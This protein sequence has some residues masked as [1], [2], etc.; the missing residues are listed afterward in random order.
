MF[1]AKSLK[2]RLTTVALPALVACLSP[3]CAGDGADPRAEAPAPS[4]SAPAQD[5]ASESGA[6][7]KPDYELTLPN[8]NALRF[9]VFADGSAGVMEAGLRGNPS[10]LS[11][12]ELEEASP[13]ELFFA[14]SKLE[15]PAALLRHHEALAAKGERPTF[16]AVIAGQEQG[17]LVP[18]IEK[19]MADGD[20]FA[21]ADCV[22]VVFTE[23]NCTLD[24]NYND[25]ECY[26]NRGSNVTSVSPLSR[27]YRAAVC[28]SQGA[29]HDKLSYQ[30]VT[31]YCGGAN[32]P[33]TIWDQNYGVG[34]Y[35]VWVWIG[36]QTQTSRYWTHQASQ[37]GAGDVFD[38]GQKWLHYPCVG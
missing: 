29:I 13:A 31:G 2:S 9:F 30:A 22:N 12:P 15:V 6:V 36:S 26:L 18:R 14:A 35:T 24:G 19:L 28:L 27:R 38:H 25:S 17:Y 33:V 16:T 3:A 32:A 10:V 7:A 1:I 11:S 34:G 20:R 23:R 5:G 37:V 21:L 8:G 4:S